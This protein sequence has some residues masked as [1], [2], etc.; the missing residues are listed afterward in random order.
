MAPNAPSQRS[1]QL[2]NI[3]L[4][5]LLSG[6]GLLLGGAIVGQSTVAYSG[7]GLFL[8][9]LPLLFLGIRLGRK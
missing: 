8:F 1:R 3:G 4:C 9:G 5:C 2:K 6:F 7:V